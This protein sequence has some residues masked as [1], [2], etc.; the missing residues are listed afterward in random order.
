[1]RTEGGVSIATASLPARPTHLQSAQ[2]SGLKSLTENSRVDSFLDIPLCLLEELADE[3][4]NA[5]GSITTLI[6]LRNGSP[7][8]H[9]SSWILDLHLCKQHFTVLG[10]LQVARAIDEEFDASAWTQVGRDDAGKAHCS[11]RVDLEGL[12]AAHGLCSR[13]EQF[14]G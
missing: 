9:R 11:G 2:L 10:H 14:D 4:H 8:N 3:E 7:C 12:C 5:G 6:V 13:V 1:M